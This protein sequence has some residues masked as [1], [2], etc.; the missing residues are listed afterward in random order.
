MLQIKNNQHPWKLHCNITFNGMIL[1]MYLAF[2]THPGLGDIG[3]IPK[4]YLYCKT[5]HYVEYMWYGWT[6]M[7]LPQG[8]LD[9]KQS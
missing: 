4:S 9:N 1:Y 3:F 2:Y 5:V 7:I 8:S 6:T